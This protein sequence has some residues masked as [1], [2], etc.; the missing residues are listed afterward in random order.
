V[1]VLCAV[2]SAVAVA[3]QSP[4]AAAAQLPVGRTLIFWNLALA[5][6]QASTV[7]GWVC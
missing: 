5:A 2:L 3:A 4:G 6:E 1:A 7:F